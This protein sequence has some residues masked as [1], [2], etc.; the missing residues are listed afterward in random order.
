M[1]N[2]QYS[3]FSIQYS[4]R[5]GF[6]LLEILIALGVISLLGVVIVQVFFTTTRSNTK[7]EIVK[8]VKQQADYAVGTMTRFIQNSRAISLAN[9]SVCV[10]GGSTISSILVTAPDGN[11]TTFGCLVDSGVQRLASVSA[12]GSEYLTGSSYTL[13]GTSCADT[14]LSFVCS[15]IPGTSTSVKIGFSLSQK[16]SPQSLYEKASTSIETTVSLRN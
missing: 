13:G 10:A 2:I 15:T 1:R 11:Q 9:G 6:T 8:D 14:T 3:E 5:N 16:G 12:S 4:K 7:T